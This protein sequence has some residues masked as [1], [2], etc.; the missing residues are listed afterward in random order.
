MCLKLCQV[1]HSS[2]NKT[3]DCGSRAVARKKIIKL[4][5]EAIRE[6]LVADTA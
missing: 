2:L 6:I 5:E 4:E 1:I 3:D